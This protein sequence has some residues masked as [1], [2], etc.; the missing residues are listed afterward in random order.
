MIDRMAVDMPEA[1]M[2]ANEDS[3]VQFWGTSVLLPPVKEALCHLKQPAGTFVFE[4]EYL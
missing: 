1:S 2:N 4:R 3:A